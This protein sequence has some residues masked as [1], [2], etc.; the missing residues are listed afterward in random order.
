M[1]SPGWQLDRTKIDVTSDVTFVVVRRSGANLKGYKVE[2]SHD[3]LEDIRSACTATLDLL[4]QRAPRTYEP[5][6][7]IEPEHEYLA[8]PIGDIQST[9][10]TTAA[11]STSADDDAS[12]GQ[13][14]P[15]E[16]TAVETDP[17][18]SELLSRASGL[19]R[20]PAPDLRRFAFLFYAAVVGNSS[21]TRSAFIR[22]RNPAMTV[23]SGR[24]P[25]AYGNVLNRVDEPLMLLDP[26]FDLVVTPEGIAVLNQSVFEALF[27]DTTVMAERFPVYAAAFASL[28]IDGPQMAQLVEHCQ[29]DSRL[30]KRLRQIFESGHLAAGKVTL[31]H[32]KREVKRLGLQEDHFFVD[33][34]LRFDEADTGTLLKLLN[35]DLFIGGFTDVGFE[36]GNK[37]KRV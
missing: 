35:E 6:L 22:K 16:T 34:N 24:R 15:V 2:A 3:A 20:L 11:V 4:G 7:E 9:N 36:A 29:R 23:R 13:V 12:N 14:Q 27:R 1:T 10:R 17:Q 5:S 28:G 8:V 19:D 25:L 37:A 30:G 31:A 26:A 18:V 33:G 21:G 32:V